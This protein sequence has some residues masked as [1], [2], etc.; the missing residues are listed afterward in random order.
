MAN[1][2]PGPSMMQAAAPDRHCTCG[3]PAGAIDSLCMMH[4]ELQFW[5]SCPVHLGS[6]AWSIRNGEVVRCQQVGL[7]HSFAD[8][9]MYTHHGFPATTK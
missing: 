6:H 5:V 7:R 2:L 3:W 8:C 4:S 9:S 1:R